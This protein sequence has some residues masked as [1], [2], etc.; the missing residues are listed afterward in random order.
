MCEQPS[1]PHAPRSFRFVEYTMTMGG[2]R[3]SSSLVTIEMLPTDKGTDLICTH[4]GAFYEGADGPKMREG[5]WRK[6]LDNLE[7]QLAR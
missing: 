1:S 6:L 2:K 5:G 7:T 4:Q 3:I